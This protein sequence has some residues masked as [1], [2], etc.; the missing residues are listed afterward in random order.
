MVYSG[1]ERLLTSAAE[2]KRHREMTLQFADGKVR[3]T[4]KE[5]S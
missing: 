3:V 1:E 2:A 4:G 5:E